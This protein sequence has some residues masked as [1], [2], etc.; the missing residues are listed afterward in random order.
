[1]QTG[2][3]IDR[4]SPLPMY[5]QLK[6]LLVKDI[7]RRRL[8]PGDRILGDHELCSR[9]DVS[10]T[11]VRQALAELENEGVI[12]RVKGRGTFVAHPKIAE[13]LV[14]SLT[15]LFEDVAAR[16]GHLRSEVRRLEVVP[17][18]DAVAADLAIPTRTPVIH[19]ERLRFVNDEPWVW[20]VTHIPES[21][22]PGLVGE[23]LTDRSLYEVLESSYGVRLVRGVRSVEAAVANAAQARLLGIRRGDPVLAL[24]SVSL[25]ESER[26]VE[27]FLALHRGDRSRFQVEL[28]RAADR[29]AGTPLLLV[30]S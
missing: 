30:T 10:R 11:V 28:N 2:D 14:Q 18:D 4:G 13:G 27:S 19:L 7:E 5:H 21:I 16:G 1:M 20:T 24:R 26:P 15:G 9:Y 23:D 3:R 12:E 29:R 8:Q 25:G 6:Q 17:A 22:A